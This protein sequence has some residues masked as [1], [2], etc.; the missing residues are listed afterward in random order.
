MPNVISAIKNIVE[1]PVTDIKAFYGSNNRIN[2]MGEGLEAYIKD[3]FANT[4]DCDEQLKTIK[5]QEEIFS[6]LGNNNNPPD[7]MLKNGD[8]IEVK[9]IEG[10]GSSLALNSSYPKNKIFANSPMITKK[11]RECEEW[12]EKDILYAVGVVSKKSILS[13]LFFVYGVD[14]AASNEIYERLKANINNGILETPNIEFGETK[15]LGRVNKVD[16]L[17]V[18]YLRIRGMWGIENPTKVF[19]YAYTEQDSDFEFV[20]IINIDKYYSFPKSDIESL[21][22]LVNDKFRISDI[23]IKEPDNP[24][25]LKQA[26]LLQL[27]T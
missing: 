5:R 2:S 26:K 11:C 23:Q 22:K 6:Y 21:E 25:K 20:A 13:K 14:Y 15:E 16:P 4:L 7:I 19:S 12:S 9:K 3:V 18:T 24:A 1:N 8:A 10:K 27:N 17:G